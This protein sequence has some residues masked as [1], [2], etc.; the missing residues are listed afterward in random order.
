AR[1]IGR[2]EA[3][4]YRAF[5]ERGIPPWATALGVAG[6]GADDLLFEPEAKDHTG[7]ATDWPACFAAGLAE[8]VTHAVDVAGGREPPPG[9]ARRA[10]TAA[11][12]ARE[13]FIGSYPLLGA[14]AASF[15]LVEDPLVCRRLEIAVAA[16]D[17]EDREIFINSAAGLDERECRFVMAH[18]LLHVGLR[19]QARRRG[20]DPWLWNVAV[21]YVVNGWLVEMGVGELPSFG[22]LYDPD[23]KGESGEAVYDRIATDLRRYRRL[24]TLRGVGLGDMLERGAPD[25]WAAGPGVDLDAFYRR[26]LEQG[27]ALHEADCRGSLPAGLVEEIRALG[28]PPPP[29]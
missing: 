10:S 4:L 19:H 18:E 15:E 6:P 1:Q 12:R 16:V 9:A 23:L 27:L 8:A 24:A 21:D 5:R 29:W 2:D 13:W 28:Q 17:A 14:L 25:W 3:R 20:R 22:L 26:C 11:E 7:R